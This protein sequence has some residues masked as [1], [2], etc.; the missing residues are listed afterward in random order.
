VVE[1]V[2]EAKVPVVQ[3]LH[4]YKVSEIRDGNRIS[5]LTCFKTTSS[6]IKYELL[7]GKIY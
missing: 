1:V 6:K 2:V 4:S 5:G 7:F 3:A